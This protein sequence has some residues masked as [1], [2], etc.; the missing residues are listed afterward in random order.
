VINCFQ[1][2]LSTFAFNFNLRRSS[3]ERHAERE[4][5]REKHKEGKGEREEKKAAHAVKK[6]AKASHLCYNPLK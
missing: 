1:A 2:L 5:A 6:A 4:R 3:K